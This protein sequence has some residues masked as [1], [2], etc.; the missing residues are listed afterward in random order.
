MSAKAKERAVHA[1]A[2]IEKGAQVAASATVGPCVVVEKGAVVGEGCILHAHC[3]IHSG[4]VLQDGVQ[5]FPFAAIGGLPQDLKFDPK[6]PSGV[7][8]GKNTV[9]REGVTVH[10]STKENGTTV[11]GENCMLM[12]NSHVAHDC[13][14]E[15]N[16]IMASAALLAGHVHVEKNVFVGGGAAFHQFIRVGE[17]AIVGGLAR[18]SHDVPPF[19]MAAE[20]DEAHGLNLIGLKRRGATAAAIAE[21][22]RLYK[23]TLMQPGDLVKLASGQKAATAEGK[24]YLSFFVPSKRNFIRSHQSL[25]QKDVE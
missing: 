16:V 20:R 17:G 19:V 22:K 7:L 14:L 13:V 15:D 25:S 8:A 1:T 24:K 11:I 9:L 23:A 12:T 10:R 18:I 3:V 5:V 6:T 21:L 2:V 4:T